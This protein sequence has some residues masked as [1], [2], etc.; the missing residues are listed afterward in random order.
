MSRSTARAAALVAASIAAVAVL[1][2]VLAQGQTPSAVVAPPL[3]PARDDSPPPRRVTVPRG[4]LTAEQAAAKP[5]EDPD[6]RWHRSD[7]PSLP[8][9]VRPCGGRPRS[10]AAWVGGRQLVLVHP[11]L[12]KAQRLVVYRDVAAARAAMA[13]RRA[14]LRRCRRRP[15]RDGTTTVWTSRA[16]RIGDEA[17]FVAS[18][19]EDPTHP[20]RGVPGHGRGVVMRKGRAVVFNFDMGQATA[21]ADLDEVANHVRDARIMARRLEAARWARR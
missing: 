3:T 15:N 19:R 10:D 20:D 8:P 5:P 11:S 17:M 14:A 12:W 13:E 6:V 18:Q 4:F 9:L 21:P 16:L 1:A 2:S 7:A